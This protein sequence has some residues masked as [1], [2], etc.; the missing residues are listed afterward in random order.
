MLSLMSPRK[1]KLL[2]VLR[3]AAIA[4]AGVVLVSPVM[5]E[6]TLEG[7]SV[8]DLVRQATAY[9][10]GS[11]TNQE[12]ADILRRN[13][14]KA[15]PGLVGMM[16]PLHPSP[17]SRAARA[18]TTRYW[19][20]S[21]LPQ[22]IRDWAERT[23]WEEN[24]RVDDREWAVVWCASLGSNA[25]M[26]H[27]A[28]IAGCRDADWHVRKEAGR[29]LV[30]TDV[31]PAVAVPILS[32]MVLQDSNF[33]VRYWAASSLG[34]LH[35]QAQAAIPALRQVTNHP[36]WWLSSRA[37]EALREVESVSLTKKGS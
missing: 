13:G 37:R 35:E 6:P 3:V 1:G 29:A 19:L 4:G 36:N 2:L 9:S 34:L 31:S 20:G 26:A 21:H 14:S 33:V 11:G 10:Q 24:R 18:I 5:H 28:L 27:P 23:A 16:G 22:P 8:R 25:W 12:A 30:R 15:V 7:Q 32:E 17:L